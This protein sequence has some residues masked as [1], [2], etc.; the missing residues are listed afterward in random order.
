M[1]RE[2]LT[3]KQLVREFYAAASAVTQRLEQK[4]REVQHSKEIREFQKEHQELRDIQTNNYQHHHHRPFKR[5][6]TPQI[7]ES[8]L[9]KSGKENASRRKKSDRSTAAL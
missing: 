7:E 3:S 1:Q 4:G 5:Q 6:D 2:E 9:P 8:E